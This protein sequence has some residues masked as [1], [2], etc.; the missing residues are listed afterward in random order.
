MSSHHW[1]LLP[2]YPH[3]PAPDWRQLEQSLLE[4]QMLLPATGPNIPHC[5]LADLNSALCAIPGAAHLYNQDWTSAADVL[6]AHMAAGHI[7]AT[8]PLPAH[9][10]VEDA[11]NALQ[12]HGIP[13]GDQWRFCGHQHA[14]WSS[15]RY[16]IGPGMRPF[17][18]ERDYDIERRHAAISLFTAHT[19]QPPFVTA[20]ENTVAPRVPGNDEELEELAPFG[21]YL[22]FV[23]AAYEDIAVTWTNP[24]DGKAHHILDLDWSE[25]LGIGWNFM[26]FDNGGD[27]DRD[28]FAAA[29]GEMIGQPA[30]FAYR[31]L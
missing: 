10:S 20:G 24:D 6:R 19:D 15:P 26:Q 5:V 9:G 23:D 14:E 12:A 4:R 3:L 18:D 1:F 2:K 11:V 17:Y 21:C 13:L 28:R 7:P 27:F 22:D 8:I 31:H 16:R 25:G 30:L 29:I